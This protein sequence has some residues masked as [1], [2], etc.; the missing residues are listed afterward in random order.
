MSADQ[1]EL[2]RVLELGGMIERHG[3]AVARSAVVAQRSFMRILV[4]RDAVS[5]SQNLSGLT[6]QCHRCCAGRSVALHAAEPEVAALQLERGRVGELRR[7]LEGM[8]LAV[9]GDAIIAERAL[10]RILMA[11]RT[12][13]T[14]AEKSQLSILERGRMRP[15][16]A[17]DAL[18]L[19]MP[20][21]KVEFRNMP[22]VVVVGIAH[23]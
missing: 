13:L 6:K 5:D 2:A 4:A 17:I 1:R 12:L 19:R 15:R 8:Y 10:V 3:D 22:M 21:T 7:V 14:Q 16:V 18:D 23:T 20:S 11:R 9:T